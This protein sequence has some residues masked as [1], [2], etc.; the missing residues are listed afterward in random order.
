MQIGIVGLPSSGKTTLF[1]T[2]TRT[3]LDEAARA[4]KQANVAVVKVPDP[5]VDALAEVF[6]PKRRVFTSIEFVD[7]VGLSTGDRESTQFTTGFLANVKSNDA[8]LHVV[9]G[10]EDPL[11]PHPEGSLDPARDV[12]LLEEEFLLSDMAAVET[13][14]EKLRKQSRV[15]NNELQKLEL[16]ALEKC[17]AALEQERPLRTLTLEPA[18]ERVIR[19]YQFLT[20]K[21]MLV[22]LNLPEEQIG[23]PETP[24]APLQ[25]R[26]AAAGL[27]FAAFSGKVE[28][29]L[30]Q[31]AEEDA[32]A[33]MAEYG[34]TESAL[35]RLIRSAY[36][37]LGLISFLTCGEDECRAWTVRRGATAQEA[38]GA[39]HT[40]LSARFIRAEQVHF[41]DFVAHGS[42]NACKENGVWRLQGKDYLVRDGDILSI[43]HG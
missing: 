27:A 18:E 14:F 36:E 3:H 12:R 23:A 32:A 38:A 33:F 25:E 8:L 5:R 35:T 4:R 6:R 34:L 24:L 10:F 19:G 39:I 30:A 20:A 17:Y 22:V 42:M 28:M 26:Y 11:C 9:R 15:P 31:L 13:R 29:E 1:Q 7:V 21:P 40:D 43:R 16:A 2:I 37:L 41:D